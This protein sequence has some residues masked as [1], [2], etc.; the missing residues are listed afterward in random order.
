MF[1]FALDKKRLLAHFQKDPVLFAYHIGDLDDRYFRQCQF[2]CTYNET[3][4]IMESVLI[5]SGLTTS[6]V[7]AFGLTDGFRY[8][9]EELLPVLPRRF[10]CHYLP[11]YRKQFLQSYR[12]TDLG[13]H[14]KMKLRDFRPIEVSPGG[15]NSIRELVPADTDEVDLFYREAYPDGY[16]E[17]HMLE[18]GKFVGM[19]YNGR[20]VSVAGVHIYVP[21]YKMAVLGAIATLP[22]HRGKGHAT[23]LTSHLCR[24]LTKE[25]LQICLNVKADNSSALKCY[26]RLGFEKTHEYQ[27]AL[28]EL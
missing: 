16:F 5:Y 6:S 4:H 24:Q 22:E 11:E 3:A 9:L 23:L 28:F 15:D 27:E 19:F 13:L 7:L 20:L 17:P 14:Y 18:T 12:E 21:T 2:A 10:F 8:L 1:T 26:L 25:K